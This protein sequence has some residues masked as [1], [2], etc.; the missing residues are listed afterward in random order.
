MDNIKEYCQSAAKFVAGKDYKQK[1]KDSLKFAA[2]AA[3]TALV[4]RYFG[5]ARGIAPIVLAGLSMATMLTEYA[6]RKPIDAH[7]LTLQKIIPGGT[8][9]VTDDQGQKRT[10]DTVQSGKSIKKSKIIALKANETLDAAIKTFKG[11]ETDAVV[12]SQQRYSKDGIFKLNSRGITHVL[13]GALTAA[14]ILSGMM[15]FKVFRIL[16]PKLAYTALVSTAA[17]LAGMTSAQDT[18]VFF[19]RK[20]YIDNVIRSV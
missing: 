16:N 17:T 4:L 6:T 5:S 18:K 10:V 1:G 8:V 19:S 15:A 14:M 7:K 3:V 9:E 11:S 20:P 2:G 12:I 13:R